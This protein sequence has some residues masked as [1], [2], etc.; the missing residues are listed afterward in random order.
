MPWS[1][2][3]PNRDNTSS[4][5]PGV[6]RRRWRG[7]GDGRFANGLRARGLRTDLVV[8]RDEGPRRQL[9]SPDGRLI[10]IKSRGVLTGFIKLVRYLYRARPGLVVANGASSIILTLLAKWFAPRLWWLPAYPST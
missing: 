7:T 5:L 9:L 3:R 8:I 2:W 6:A 1:R 10:A 4:R